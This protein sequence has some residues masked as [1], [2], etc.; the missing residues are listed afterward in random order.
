MM[1]GNLNFV[2]IGNKEKMEELENK[3]KELGYSHEHNC[4]KN[5][6]TGRLTYHIYDIPTQINFSVLSNEIIEILKTYS[7]EFNRRVG[8]SAEKMLG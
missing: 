6:D 2:D 4:E 3:L 8:V 5:T 7:S 1:L